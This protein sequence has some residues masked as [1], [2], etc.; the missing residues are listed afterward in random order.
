MLRKPASAKKKPAAAKAALEKPA[1]A[2]PEK[3]KN[4]GSGRVQFR[5]LG[6]A[7]FFDPGPW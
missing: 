3:K 7:G 6:R 1:K 5:R 4:A 2:E